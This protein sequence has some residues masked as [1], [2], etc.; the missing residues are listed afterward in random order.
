MAKKQPDAPVTALVNTRRVSE[1]MQVA[2][3]VDPKDMRGKEGLD[4][5]D[6][7]LPRIAV[8]QDTSYEKKKDNAKFIPGLDSGQIFNSLTQEVYGETVTFAVLKSIKRAMEFNENREVVDFDVPWNDPRCEFTTDAR[9]KRVKPQA[10]RMYDYIVLTPG[11]D[12]AMISCSST[13][14]PA[15]K[16]LNSLLLARTGPSWAGLFTMS[17][18]PDSAAKGDFFNVTF[19][20]AGKTPPDM[21]AEADA[22]FERFKNAKVTTT[23]HGKDDAE[24]DSEGKPIPF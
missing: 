9:G 14:M 7:I 11:G 3:G 17:V 22:Q 16:R 13:K 21:L 18:V 10:T 24:T 8:C 6:V 5:S 2:E 23:D 1:A 20:L 15:G 4:T 19:N 12:I